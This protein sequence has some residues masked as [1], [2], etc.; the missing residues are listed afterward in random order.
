[1]EKRIN[2]RI[3]WCK[4]FWYRFR[5][6]SILEGVYAIF[7]VVFWIQLIMKIAF[8]R[9][10]D[11]ITYTKGHKLDIGDLEL[12]QIS[13]YYIDCFL[14]I[15]LAIL[16]VHFINNL[17]SP[18]NFIITYTIEYIKKYFLS[19]FTLI[20]VVCLLGAI[21]MTTVYG[22]FAYG[23][24]N[25]IQSLIAFFTLLWRG[26]LMYPH[27]YFNY[28]ESYKWLIDRIGLITLFVFIIFVHFILRY[29]VVNISVSTLNYEFKQ[30]KE[31]SKINK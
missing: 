20:F 7:A 18:V 14:L 15:A 8:N 30:N 24:T 3:G 2:K 21:G 31:V 4:K 26:S 19:A 27:T 16:S 6:P 5:F 9:K 29:F 11:N 13:I 1:M 22:M 12:F 10:F 23:Y 17:I 28:T 25:Y